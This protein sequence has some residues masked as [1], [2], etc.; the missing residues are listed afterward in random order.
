MRLALDF[1]DQVNLIRAYGD[2]HV[3]INA[4]TRLERSF[5]LAPTRLQEHW[6]PQ[7]FDELAA[8]HFAELLDFKPE[9]VLL[10]TG[11]RQRFPHPSLIRPLLEAGIAVESMDTAA[12]CRTY[13][14]VVAEGRTVIA[15]LL[16]I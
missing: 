5:I 2:G 4:D 6:Q 9:M 7:S 12:A 16:M 14:I 3:T 13:N 10:G 15:A 1:D 11:A 8:E